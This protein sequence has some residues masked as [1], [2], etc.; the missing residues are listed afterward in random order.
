MAVRASTT[1]G[2][3]H[4]AR[5]MA[6]R[7][8]LAGAGPAAQR[9]PRAVRALFTE[10]PLPML[11]AWGAQRKAACN[12]A[13][14]RLAQAHG[15]DRAAACGALLDL[16]HA[17]I[18]TGY[19]GAAAAH[20]GQLLVVQCN[21]GAAS[22]PCDLSFVPLRGPGGKVAGALC[23]V[24]DAGAR[25][26]LEAR[27]RAI[28]QQARS[29]DTEFSIVYSNMEEVAYH[30]ARDSAGQFR[31]VSVNRAFFHSTGMREQDVLGKLVQEV[32]P[33]PSIDMV[34]QHHREAID[35]GATVH[36]EEVTRFPSG[37][38]VGAVSVTPVFG[39]GGE[40][41]DLIGT[42]HDI[43]EL[44]H[45][46]DQLRQANASLAGAMTEQE[47]LAAQLRASE[48]RLGHAL[49]STGEGVWDWNIQ[50]DRVFL[51]PRWKELLGVTGPVPEDSSFWWSLVH[52][53]DVPGSIEFLGA[54]LR[55]NEPV[56][57]NE[58][59]LRHASGRYI[60]VRTR[61]TVVERDAA[62]APVRMV[63]TIADVT[64]IR[65]LREEL[66]RSHELFSKLTQ[67]VPGALF[68]MVREPN[69]RL[70][71]SYISAMA[72]EIFE[73]APEEIQADIRCLESR[74]DHPDRAR[75]R[76]ALRDAAINLQP[77]RV[78]YRVM[79]PKK[80]LCWREL[81]ANPT[82]AEGGRIVWHGF[83]TDISERKRA[84]NTIRQFNETLERRA[85]YDALTG[86]PNRVLF[87]D[88]LEHE[89]RQA[90]SAPYGIALL[91]I[92][93]DRFKEVNDLQGHDAGDALLSEAARRI[94]GCL[95]PGDTVARLGGDEFTVILTETSELAHVEQTAQRI[96]DVL[97]LPFRLGIEQ[98]YISG[99]IG[100]TMFPGDASGPEQLMRNADQAMYRSKN[101]GRNQLS[102]FEPTMQEAAMRRLKLASDLRR[103]LADDQLELHFQP[104]VDS[105]SGH[106]IKAEALLRWRR[107]GAPLALP[108]EFIGIAE[109]TGLIHEIGNWV[110]RGAAGWSQRWSALLG[111]PFQVSINKSPVQFQPHDAPMDWV[112][113]LAEHGMAHNSIAIEITEG[114]LLNLSEAVF[115]KLH[116]LQ[117]GG[118]EVSI[119]D[120]GTGYSS[121]N[122]LKRLDIDYLK[123]D[124]S[125]VAEML[126]DRTSQTIT[127]TIIVMAHKLGLQVIAEGVETAAQRYWLA[128]Q[129]CDYVQG[130]LFGLP[131]E[132]PQFE[133]MLAQQ[134]FR[135]A[136]APP[137]APGP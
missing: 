53:D 128:A 123:I 62:G 35:S 116:E 104:I 19:A 92:D 130:F 67:Q 134:P 10:S 112:R 97:R 137:G 12:A 120:F 16:A 83:T 23:T 34:L 25:L 78:E 96:L 48:E 95:G 99:S 31:F 39:P 52:P 73:R 69:G 114:V 108:D 8:A 27:L 103:A 57:I 4:L 29:R 133:A 65:Q 22:V 54:F 7:G 18:D 9:W 5:S 113:Y 24:I 131:V 17:G 51:S 3:A 110:F 91:F 64:A 71:C 13:F 58:H 2:S 118:V 75:I 61:G 121:M 76:R 68:E 74:I 45:A 82:R 36:W 136:G 100:I 117:A 46:E 72:H 38:R 28:E 94:E 41:T 127:E 32:I 49:A 26:R 124:R 63:G 20:P 132:A 80:G 11:L 115:D 44:K 98:A 86:L 14:D 106:I 135:C 6:H 119:D 47:R 109:E 60:W 107:P 56:C 89:M 105:V 102:F 87:R 33:A 59:R 77:W 66:E 79:L 101:A 129:Q 50:T 30:L 125:F 40:C 55:S 21:G 15:L 43:T 84:E 88:R 126:H 81:N 111:R 1:V 42:V 90:R 70:R 85:H 122:Y 93:L 37:Q